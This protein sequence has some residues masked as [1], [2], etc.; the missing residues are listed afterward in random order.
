MWT[1]ACEILAIMAARVPTPLGH[2]LVLVR[3]GGLD[4]HV[5][6]V[7]KKKRGQELVEVGWERMPNKSLL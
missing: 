1:N 5:L 4:R 3:R 2:S 7:R 6:L